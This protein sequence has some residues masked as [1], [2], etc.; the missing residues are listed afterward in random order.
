MFSHVMMK[1]KPQHSAVL[2]CSSFKFLTPKIVN[3]GP[4][5]Y[6][7]VY[8]GGWSV[9]FKCGSNSIN[10]MNKVVEKLLVQ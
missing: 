3:H 1:L 10:V 6:L 8:V 2:N 9:V 4:L 7:C 5:L